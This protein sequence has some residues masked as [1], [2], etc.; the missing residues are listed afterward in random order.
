MFA[1]TD[2][3]WLIFVKLIPGHTT[4]FCRVGKPS[5]FVLR[6]NV[7]GRLSVEGRLAS[8][9]IKAWLRL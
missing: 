9:T 3:V 8:Q 6:L 4:R 1:S 2:V 5:H 7:E